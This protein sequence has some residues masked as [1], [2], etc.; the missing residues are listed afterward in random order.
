MYG[1]EPAKSA[2]SVADPWTRPW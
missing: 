1:H 2:G